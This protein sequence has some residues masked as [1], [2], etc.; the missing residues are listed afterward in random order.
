MK[1]QN[2]T[3]KT[4]LACAAVGWMCWSVGGVCNAQNPSGLSPDLQ[5]VVKLSQAHMPDDVIRNYIASTGKSYQLSA[6]DIIYLNGQGVSAGV[7]SALQTASAA[8]PPPPPTA[9]PQ[10]P[11]ANNAPP[12][13]PPPDAGNAAPDASEATPP[14]PPEVN[15][16]YFHDQLA[17]FGSWIDVGGVTYWRP[18]Q[19][20]AVNPDWR[21][22]YDMGQWVQ[23]D[24]GLYW[25][26]DY[27][28]GDIPFHYGRWVLLPGVGWVWSPDYVWG[29]AWVFWRHDDVDGCIG[30]APL[31]V[32]A[33]FINGGLW[34]HG[35]AVGVDFDFGLG[36]SCFTF[37]SYDHFHE[38]FFRMRGREWAYHIDRARLHAYW[39]HSVVH[40]DFRRDDHGR[41]VNDGIGRDR[42]AS[43]THVEHAS[44]EERAPVG[45]RN[46]L[47]AARTQ[48]LRNE[49][50]RGNL[51]TEHGNVNTERGNLGTEHGNFDN[52]HT[53]TERT[54]THTTETTT[55]HATVSK[56][57]R[58]PVSN[59]PRT[60]P[61]GGGQHG[62]QKQNH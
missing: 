3:L 51:S 43:L 58:P 5:E 37:V 12:P 54:T 46:K 4:V 40:N 17:P 2:W 15:F 14:P 50:H 6:E 55:T 30:W 23:T 34:F 21:P 44:F 1:N 36:E 9:P 61:S 7:I 28:W 49:D 8:N 10:P 41:F 13:P 19:A 16:Q 59:N 29:P 48:Q 26:S 35:V 62:N 57:Y 32:G 27:T 33:V 18:D 22:Y 42:M 11:D 47:E 20:I 53:A 60:T 24:D 38:P 56:V 52:E 25:Q 39:G 45:D 31:P